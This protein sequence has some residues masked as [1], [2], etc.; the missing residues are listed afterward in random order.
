MKSKQQ[1]RAIILMSGGVD[2]SV[3]AALLKDQ[4]YDVIGV[5]ILGWTGTK[6]F[7]CH[8]Q[9][10][11]ADAKKVALQLGLPFY[12]VNLSK[13]YEKN[14]IDRFFAGYKKGITPNPD[15][16]CNR[17]IKFK[18]VWQAVR[19]FEPDYIATGH[20]ARI[21]KVTSSKSQVT[22]R[23]PNLG[24]D[25]SEFVTCRHAIFK[26]RDEMKDQSY[27]LWGIDREMLPKILFPIGELE[28]S[29]VRAL[30][31]KYQLPT[32]TKKDSQGICFI[33]PLKVREFLTRQLRP[34]PGEAVLTDGRLIAQHQGAVLYTIGQRLAVGSVDWTGDVPPLFVIAK[35]SPNNRLIVGNETET[36]AD[37]LIAGSANWL[38]AAEFV[39]Q[40]KIRYRQKDVSVTLEAVS[41]GLKVKF[42]A[43]VRAITPGQSIVFYSNDDQLIG[44]AIIERVPLQE[45]IIQNLYV[46]QQTQPSADR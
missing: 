36:E 3:S 15:I 38:G 39:S 20:Y 9:E 30:A 11:E 24:L 33:G 27:F 25:T 31:K 18:A 26:A 1:R 17:E 13:E 5:Y 21:C 8:W 46:Q 7:P 44:G 19:Q 22:K 45:K 34:R 14:V 37:E 42:S 2:S 28:K 12:T 16:L 43:P 23:F 4:G 29:E 6:D 40:A 41:D 10:E 35:D 32:A